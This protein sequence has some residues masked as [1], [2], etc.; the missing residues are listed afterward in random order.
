VDQAWQQEARSASLARCAAAGIR[1]ALV[2]RRLPLAVAILAAI[3][4]LPALTGGWQL[5]DYFQRATLLG[6][7]DSKPIQVFVQY[8]DRP[9][10]LRQMDFGTMPWWGSPDLHQAFLRYASTLTMML[11]YHLWPNHPVLMHLHSLLWLAAAVLAAAVLY[12]EV[13]GAT[14]LAGWRL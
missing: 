4:M 12:R 8:I 11:D 9:H 1:T 13:L 10:N 6:Y 2:H 5:D 3:A 14:W 7:G